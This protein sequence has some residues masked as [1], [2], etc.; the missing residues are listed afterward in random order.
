MA[1]EIEHRFAVVLA[2]QVAA[3]LLRGDNEKERARASLTSI[4]LMLQNATDNDDQV[5]EILSL[6][7]KG[8]VTV[9]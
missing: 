2:G 3:G 7:D 8:I 4:G 5:C 1:K 9:T 6:I